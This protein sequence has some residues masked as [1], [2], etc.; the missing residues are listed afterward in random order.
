[1]DGENALKGKVGYKFNQ[2]LFISTF[3]THVTQKVK[4][5][6]FWF[7]NNFDRFKDSTGLSQLSG[8]NWDS[9]FW[10]CT[11]I[12]TLTQGADPSVTMRLKEI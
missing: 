5:R 3:P 8:N 10:S 9:S 12:E 1:M 2:T 11:S 7:K 6:Q 4:I